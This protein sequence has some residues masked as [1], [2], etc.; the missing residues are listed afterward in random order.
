MFF[1]QHPC[2]QL[3]VVKELKSLCEKVETLKAEREVVENELKTTSCDM[4]SKFTQVC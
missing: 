2:I 4:T 3:Q 1:N